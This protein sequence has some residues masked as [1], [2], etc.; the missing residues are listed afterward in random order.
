MKKQSLKKSLQELVEEE[1]YSM[2]KPANY[3]YFKAEVLDDEHK[4]IIVPFSDWH[5]GNVDCK[6]KELYDNLNWAYDKPNVYIITNGDLIEAK[7]RNRT[8]DGIFTQINPNKQIDFVLKYLKPFAKDKRLIAMVNGNHEDAITLETGVDITSLFAKDLNVPYLK[9]G[10]FFSVKADNE[11]YKFYITHGSSGATLPYT[12]IKA[13]LNLSTFIQGVDAYIMG[14][15]HDK[16]DHTQ[17]VYYVDSRTK[18]VKTKQ[19]HYILSGHYLNYLNSY[20]QMKSMRP[21]ATGTPK[22]K[23]KGDEHQIRVSL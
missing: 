2:R 21:S 8:G 7:T 17:D 15:V 3:T 4:A 1:D 12:K 5:W 13:C 23:I 9:N 19:I 18:Q 16:Q 14:H 11:L 6:E 20:A 22:I 10:G